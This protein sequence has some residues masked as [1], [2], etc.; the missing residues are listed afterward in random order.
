MS[1]HQSE[2]ITG[3]WEGNLREY[4]RLVEDKG[5]EH[6]YLMSAGV[7]ANVVRLIGPCSDA[8]LLDVGCGSGWLLRQVRPAEGYECDI[9]AR[10]GMNPDASFE[11]Q[12]VQALTYVSDSFD[13]VVAS[14]VLCWVPELEAACRQLYRVT[15]DGGRLI[16]GLAHPYFFRTGDISTAGDFVLARD[17]SHPCSFPVRLGSEEADSVPYYYRPVS[18]YINALIDSGWRLTHTIDWFLDM[19]EYIRQTEDRKVEKVRTGKVPMFWFAEC[20]KM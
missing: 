15:R 13:V 20:M 10:D 9:E 12:D 16:V 18:Y 6:E 5:D 11:V 1:E 2:P 8:R 14:L 17:L 4:R 3:N 19:D 7:H